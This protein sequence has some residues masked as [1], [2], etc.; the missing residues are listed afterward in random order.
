MSALAP[1]RQEQL[2]AGPQAF[3]L[4]PQ[5]ACARDPRGGQGQSDLAA[6]STKC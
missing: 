6:V 2:G 1:G 5:L 3:S 4:A